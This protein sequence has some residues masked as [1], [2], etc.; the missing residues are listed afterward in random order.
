MSLVPQISENDS[1]LLNIRP[2]ISRRTGDVSDPNPSLANPCGVPVPFTGCSIAPITSL[3]PVIQT[4]EMESLMR[5]QS[6]Q[7]AVLGGLMQ[8][9]TTNIEDTIPGV[10]RLPGVGE[11]LAQ[12]K[13]LTTKTELVIFLRATVIR[14]DSV[15]GDF[16][17]FRNLLPGSDFF[18]RPNPTKPPLLFDPRSP[19]SE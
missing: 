3:I 19:K 4:R 14:D 1:V 17:N 10:N 16:A 11:L 12:R 15:N 9:S 7:T 13:D 6:G 8:D 18:Q 5:L 2:T